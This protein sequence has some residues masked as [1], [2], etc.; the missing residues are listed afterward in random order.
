MQHQYVVTAALPKLA[1]L[2]VPNLRDP[3][4]L[5]YLRQHDAGLVIGGYERDPRPFTA[6]IPE[7]PDP[8]VQP[9]DAAQFEAL[10]SAA[11]ERVPCIRGVELVRQVNGLESFT[12]DGE[13]LLGP[14]TQVPGIWFACGFCAH[15]VSGAGGVGKVLAEWIVAGQPSIELT[16]L[17]PD[18]FGPQ[19]ADSDY[20]EQAARRVYAT[21]YDLRNTS[22][23]QP[24]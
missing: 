11:A 10:R 4:K 24:Q 13:F 8:T 22:G 20:V 19:A 23:K 21:Y 9:F 2:T 3:D 18:R 5:V 14:S 17:S 12:P 1:G 16:H 7:R 15:G 6:A